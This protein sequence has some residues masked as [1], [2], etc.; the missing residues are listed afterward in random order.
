MWY[1][2][3]FPAP[4]KS[5]VR[6]LLVALVIGIGASLLATAVA[7]RPFAKTVELKTYDLRMRWTANPA[8][9]RR[10]I[11]LVT[12]DEDS[13][14]SLAHLVGRWP[15]PRVM[16]AYLIDFLA[17]APVRAIVYDIM[18]T[19]PDRQRDF[20]IGEQDWSG[21]ASDRALAEST[22]RA[23]NVVHLADVTHEGAVEQPAESADGNGFPDTFQRHPAWGFRLDDDVQERPGVALPYPD[24]ASASRALAHNFMVLDED[25]PVRHVLPFVRVRDRFIPSLGVAG[26][27]LAGGI[28]PADVRIERRGLRFRDAVLPVQTADVPRF[29][30]DDRRVRARQALINYAGP[31]VL[32][33]GRT[34]TYRSYSFYHLW[35]SEMQILEGV[36]P[37]ID[38][39]TLRDAIVFVGTTAAGLHDVFQTPFGDTGKMPGVQVHASVA[40]SILSR[41]FM[42]PAAAWAALVTTLLAALVVGIAG[43]FLRPSVATVI[44]IATAAGVGAVGVWLFSRGIW[45][46]M[47]TPIVAVIAASFAGVGYQ[48][49]VEGR[50]RRRISGLFGRYVS[51][52]V[53]EQLLTNPTLARLGGQRREMTV[54]FSDIRGFTSIS[55]VTTPEEVVSQLNEYF[56]RMVEILFRHRGTLDKF[57]GDMVMAL[58]GAP[59]DDPDHADHA[60]AT[61]LEMVAQL[62]RLNEKWAAEG[63]ARVDIGIGINSGEM[64]AGNIGAETIRSYTVIG[65][66]VNLGARLESLNKEFKTRIIIS[67]Y[68]RARLRG[69]YTLRSLGDVVVKGKTQ[70]VAIYTVEA[71]EAP[72][73]QHGEHG[74]FT[75]NTEK[76]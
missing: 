31:A 7:T 51:R 21:E 66:A 29:P 70:P 38:P 30:G 14:R 13:V 74:G 56:S 45:L 41:R 40:D 3:R 44:S 47:T 42:R 43:V 57:V 22:R 4:S 55:E 20:K 28:A 58:Y 65:D 1:A 67:E 62:E 76:N 8:A 5:F 16:H 36:K 64:I 39:A 35:Y 59:L 46:P 12:I 48:Y 37:N 26:A 53:F 71:A 33:D 61:A 11:V 63:R 75:K 25:G 18:F 54:L 50:E 17:R 69:S 10:D 9:A 49:F 24:L 6:K 34:T 60:V 32:P 15:W 73:S 72:K 23:G 68:T 19:E 52:D 27:L 2:A